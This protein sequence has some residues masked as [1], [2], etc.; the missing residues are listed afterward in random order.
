MK[1]SDKLQERHA[2]LTL[3]CNSC[4]LAT[5]HEFVEIQVPTADPFSDQD[6]AATQR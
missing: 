2:A 6:F 1:R 4:H 5:Q 3:G